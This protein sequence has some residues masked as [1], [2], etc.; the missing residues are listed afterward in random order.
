MMS[1]SNFVPLAISRST[2]LANKNDVFV[3]KGSFQLSETKSLTFD[4]KKLF[5]FFTDSISS[6]GLSTVGLELLEI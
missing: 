3:P 6:L 5:S 1:V 4:P 2:Y